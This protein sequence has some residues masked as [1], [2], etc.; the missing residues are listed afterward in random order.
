MGAS[1]ARCPRTPITPRG[2]DHKRSCRS[3]LCLSGRNVTILPGASLDTYPSV[4]SISTPLVESLGTAPRSECLPSTRSAP[5]LPFGSIH[6]LPQFGGPGQTRTGDKRFRKPLLYPLSYGTMLALPRGFEPLTS[7]LEG[8]HSVLLSY[9]SNEKLSMLNF[10][11]SFQVCD[12]PHQGCYGTASLP[13]EHAN[14][15]ETAANLQPS[16]GPWHDDD[17]HHLRWRRRL[18]LTFEYPKR[19][20]LPYV[21]MVVLLLLQVELETRARSWS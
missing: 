20:G 19:A 2:R 17:R 12:E 8:R 7:D 10:C 15:V 1:V 16:L 18:S 9:G 5:S 13:V 11:I 21:L 4:D 6:C 3:P 14:E